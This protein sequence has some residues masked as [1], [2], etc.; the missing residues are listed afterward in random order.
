MKEE[1]RECEE[2]IAAILNDFVKKWR[3]ND[4]DL[5]VVRLSDSGGVY[6]VGVQI[7]LEY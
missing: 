3:P 5:S 4:I 7:E 6:S 2:K 1:K